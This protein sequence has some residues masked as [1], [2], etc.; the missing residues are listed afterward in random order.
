MTVKLPRIRTI[1]EYFLFSIPLYIFVLS[2]LLRT[3]F[4]SFSLFD[5]SDTSV[6]F[7]SSSS[8]KHQSYEKTDALV[9]PDPHLQCADSTYK[10][11]ILSR[12]PLIVYIEGFLSDEEVRHFID[13]AFVLSLPCPVPTSL[14]IYTSPSSSHFQ[15]STI[16]H[17][18]TES[19][20][21]S[22][23][24]SSRALLP[25]D[26]LVQCLEARAREFQGW[27][28]D[29]YIERL[30]VQKYEAGGH[31]TYHFD[32]SGDVRRHG[33]GRLSTFMV[34]LGDKGVQG[35]GTK[36][37]R[38]RRPDGEDWCWAVEC[39]EDGGEGEEQEASMGITFKPI[40]GNA[41][42]WENF[43]PD[44]RGYEETWHA[45]LP[46]ESG[47]KYGLNIWSWYQPGYAE[48]IAQENEREGE[49]ERQSWANEV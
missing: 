23:R 37:P 24:N 26:H 13:L 21:P 18:G 32:W 34:Y 19:F 30:W 6:S 20:N 22:I 33:A 38:L 11:R 36:F 40:K 9:I 8:A 42:Y 3:Y 43:R 7:S 15:P 5:G 25:R 1:F 14:L 46:V 45:G 12:E 28:P 35:G 17:G 16:H 47:V 27:R 41:V 39:P 44:G 10:T 31:Y 49:R 4:P 2:P 48:A 29:V